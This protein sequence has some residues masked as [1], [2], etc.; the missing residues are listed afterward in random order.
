MT[1][2][3]FVDVQSFSA[4]QHAGQ[5]VVEMLFSSILNLHA[6]PRK[7]VT[8]NKTCQH[9]FLAPQNRR[10]GLCI[11]TPHNCRLCVFRDRQDLD[12]QDQI[13]ILRSRS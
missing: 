8:N 2:E 6:M 11:L 5:T 13:V 10:L 9:F 7:M 3:V 1:A 4:L 12:V